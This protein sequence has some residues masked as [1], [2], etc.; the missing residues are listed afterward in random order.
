MTPFAGVGV[1]AAMTDALE[2]GRAII[3]YSKETSEKSF[4]AVIKDYELELFPRGERFAKQ[5]LK[6]LIGHFSATGSENFAAK[7]KAVHA[8]PS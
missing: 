2:L 6:G 8:S 5:T 1:N 3:A 4:E 7:M